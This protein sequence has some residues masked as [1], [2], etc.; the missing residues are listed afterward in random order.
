[1]CT[2]QGI[3]F[4]HCQSII[5]SLLYFIDDGI[6]I[7]CEYTSYLAPLQ[8]SKLYNEVRSSKD[9]DK[10]PEV[11]RVVSPDCIF[12]LDFYIIW[13]DRIFKKSTLIFL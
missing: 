3:T 4:L 1:M 7:P 11:C 13:L 12:S 9:K 6:S 5:R 2:K 10:P 8:S